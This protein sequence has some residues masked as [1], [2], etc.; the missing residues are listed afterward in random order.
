MFATFARLL[1]PGGLLMFTSGSEHGEVWSQ[2]GG[3]ALYHASLD[4]AD[5]RQAAYWALLSGAAGHVYGNHN[6]WQFWQPGREPGV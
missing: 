4:A 3:E 1:E 5:V 6:V 2:N